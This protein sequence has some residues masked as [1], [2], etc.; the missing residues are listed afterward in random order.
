MII[1]M[2]LIVFLF[3]QLTAGL[4]KAQNIDSILA[5][6]Y[7]YKMISSGRNYPT[8]DAEKEDLGSI[9]ILLHEGFSIDQIAGYFKWPAVE[10][11]KKIDLLLKD[12][13]LK[14][15]IDGAYKPNIMVITLKDNRQYLNVDDKLVDDTVRFLTSR[16]SQIETAYKKING[17]KNI[18]FSD[19]SFFILSDVMLD[20]W[21]IRNVEE[22]ILK[23]A[24]TKR[25]GMNYYYSIQENENKKSCEAFGIYGNS[26]ISY[27]KIMYAMYGNQRESVN[28]RTLSTEKLCELFKVKNEKDS[29]L[30]RE[31]LLSEFIK[32][33]QDADHKVSED[34]KTGFEKLGFIE[35][36]KFVAPVFDQND[37]SKLSE[38]ASLFTEELVELLDKYLNDLKKQYHG[39]AYSNEI[40][41][42]EF[43]IWWYHLYYTKVTDK[44]IE[45]NLI[46]KPGSGIFI[47]LVN[48]K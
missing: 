16:M 11:N 7:D 47:Y 38:M 30:I 40:S 36:D 21:Q 1:M 26:Y 32:C 12:E 24:R 9:C 20:N 8:I 43:F 6:R 2:L 31:R 3:L 27:G 18:D 28:F 22:K 13:L 19:A 44:L 41:F 35:N 10:M 48:N 45:K 17:L 25:N 29:N 5:A 33:S 39:S 37:V 34:Y 14:K 42:E 15:N 23:A 4:A 46:K